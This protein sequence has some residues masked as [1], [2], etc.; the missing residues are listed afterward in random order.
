MNDLQKV[1]FEILKDIDKLC[2]ENNIT[3]YL[4]GGTALGAIRH[5]GFIPWDDDIDIFMSIEHYDRFKQ[6][7]IMSDMEDYVLQEN[8]AYDNYWLYSKIRKKGT[9]QIEREEDKSSKKMQGIFIDIFPLRKCSLNVLSQY[10]HYFCAQYLTMRAQIACG[11]ESNNKKQQVILKLSKFMPNKLLSKCAV[12]YINKYEHRSNYQYCYF[13]VGRG[14][15]MKKLVFDKEMFSAPIYCSF[16]SDLFPVSSKYHEY[17]TQFYGDYMK[18]PPEEKRIQ[19]RH[20]ILVD[21]NKDY[22]EYL[23]CERGVFV[24]DMQWKEYYP[25]RMPKNKL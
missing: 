17:L 23:N 7:F 2:K 21:E 18:L 22:S 13:E 16:E 3:Y 8:Y 15:S 10:I 12:K 11:W 1:Q 20:G 19:F 5:K 14:I 25:R 24:Q 4:A 9:T 6:L